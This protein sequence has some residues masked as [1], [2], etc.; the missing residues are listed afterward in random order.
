MRRFLIVASV[1]LATSLPREAMAARSA[2]DPDRDIFVLVREKTIQLPSSTEDASPN[3]AIVEGVEL[4]SILRDPAIRVITRACPTAKPS[5]ALKTLTDGRIVRSLDL[6]QL[7]RVRVA[8]PKDRERVLASLRGT[9]GVILA[10]ANQRFVPRAIPNDPSFRDQW[11]LLNIGQS[12]GVVGADIDA[13]GGWGYRT[14]SPL[15]LVGMVEFH[16]PNAS[17]PEVAGRITGDL[18]GYDSDYYRNHAS[19]VAGLIGAAG[20]NAAGI[21]GVNWTC[22]ILSKVI[23]PTDV[24]STAQ[25]IKD[26]VDASCRVINLSWGHSN[27]SDLVADAVAYAHQHHVLVIAAMPEAG[28]PDEYPNKHQD[29]G[30][31]SVGAA[32]NTNH[33]A[34]YS[35]TAPYVD[36][37]A[38]GGNRDG[39]SLHDIYSLATLGPYQWG[40]GTSWAAPQVTGAAALLWEWMTNVNT[41]PVFG[42][43]P[44]AEDLRGLIRATA[45]DIATPGFDDSTG[46]GRLNM[47]RMF[48]WEWDDS[49]GSYGLSNVNVHIGGVDQGASSLYAMR[50]YNE[51]TLM[52]NAYYPNFLIKLHEVRY[53]VSSAGTSAPTRVWGLGSSTGWPG[54]GLNIPQSNRALFNSGWCGPVGGTVSASGFTLHTYVYEVYNLL[55]TQ[56]LGWFPCQPNQATFRYRRFERTPSI[57]HEGAISATQSFFVPEAGSVGSPTTGSAAV[58]FFRACP[59]ND[60][61]SSLYNNAR[62]RVVLRDGSGIGIPNVDAADIAI[63]F[64]GGTA[65]QGFSGAGADSVIANSAYNQSPL[66]PDVRTITADAPTDA[67]GVTYITFT[68]STPGSPGVGT[69]DPLRKWGHFDSELPVYVLGTK[70]QGRLTSASENGSYV[71]RI[72]NF[73]FTHTLGL[74]RRARST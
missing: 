64:N 27:Y 61:G 65:A 2:A 46:Y 47:R 56:F 30:V 10:E 15:T 45:D 72:K 29:L 37:C 25:A 60:G 11:H 59:N 52:S 66:C 8:D 12:Q 32:A 50:I 38:P 55:G 74:L 19:A 33:A 23:A 4:A 41:P 51:P 31:L 42:N 57:S 48:D 14:G 13:I 6:S 16:G 69:R 7:Y 3:A 34:G 20:N 35:A 28:V 43:G 40:S 9:I 68:G 17:H 36:V 39:Q 49:P 1:L 26:A 62:I 58:G 5:Q 24:G 22:P 53:T 73:D 54:I 18:A 67:N 44:E 21:A 63:L 71:L 70:L